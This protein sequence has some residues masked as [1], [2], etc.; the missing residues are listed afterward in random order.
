MNSGSSAS[1]LALVA[2]FRAVL[3]AEGTAMFLLFVL[4][5]IGWVACREMLLA[6]A[7]AWLAAQR[8][9]WPA[10]PGW[11]RVL[12]IGI[13]V[14]W[15]VDG[16]LQ[17]QPAMPAWLPSQVITPAADGSPGWVQHMVHWG[18]QIWSG[19]PVE[20]AAG[21]VWIQLG[22]GIWLV[23]VSSPRWSRL[24]GLVS[25]GWGLVVWV[26]GEAFG[27]L[28][29]PA[30][31]WLTGAPGAAFF[32]CVAGA[33]LA[34][35]V[36]HWRDPELGRRI[37]Q[38][39]GA[40]LVASAVFQA[41]PGRGFWEGTLP[42][43]ANARVPGPLARAIGSMAQMNQPGALHNLAGWFA[44]LVAS[45]GFA[46]NLVAVVTLAAAGAGLLIGRRDIIGPVVGATIG[47][48]LAD[49]VLVQDFGVFGGLGTDPNSM[50]PQAVILAAGLLATA[51]RPALVAAS[52][53]QPQPAP[54]PPARGG[55]MVLQPVPAARRLGLAFGTA[56][57]SAVLAVWAVVMVVLLGAA[58]MAMAAAHRNAPPA[59]A[60]VSARYRP[61]LASA[62]P[63][64]DCHACADLAGPAD[65]GLVRSSAA[66]AQRV[67]SAAPGEVTMASPSSS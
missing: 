40:L 56:S 43:T 50:L 3:L 64:A 32:Y 17:A 10:E 53:P 38:A 59:G 29:G 19:D 11:R 63:N 44:A 20:A 14:L 67:T 24:A 46:V 36:R 66:S 9:R 49:W 23:S 42:G 26:F 47:F 28:L 25:L 18:T 51:A 2:D 45:H 7:R 41:W 8:G 57:A 65:A 12:R 61:M 60:S 27:G 33:L 31:S 55:L 39:A 5:A 16:L 6:R 35:P 34:L 15:I 58:P 48:C 52:V 21:A 37:L 22:I 30:A 62:V 1:S 54:L 4:L 13:G